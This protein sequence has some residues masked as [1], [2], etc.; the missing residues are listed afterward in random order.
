LNGSAA[1]CSLANVTRLCRRREI[2]ISSGD[3]TQRSSL[4]N[5]LLEELA[6]LQH[7]YGRVSGG[8]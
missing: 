4:G 7:Q 5:E 6:G 8:M 1:T 2:A 3:N